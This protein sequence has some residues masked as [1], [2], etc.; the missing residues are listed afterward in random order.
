VL[1]DGCPSGV[2]SLETVLP[3]KDDVQKVLQDFNVLVSRY[4]LFHCSL[5]SLHL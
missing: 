4:L 1:E 3:S 2:I 5:I